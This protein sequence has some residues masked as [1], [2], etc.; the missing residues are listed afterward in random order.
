MNLEIVILSEVSLKAK[1]THTHTESEI[2]ISYDVTYMWKLK[3][4]VQMH[5]LIKQ[6]QTHKQKKNVWLPTGN[7]GRDKLG[8]KQQGPTVEHREVYSVHHNTL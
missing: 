2:Q 8:V 3:K 7:E 5:L 6:K 1:Y 4:I